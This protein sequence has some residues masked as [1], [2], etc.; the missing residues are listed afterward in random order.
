[1]NR[2][3][4]LGAAGDKLVCNAKLPTD[5]EL[6]TVHLAARPQVGGGGNGVGGGT[7]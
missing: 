5:A 1:M 7:T 6:W 3:Y 4:Y 2:G